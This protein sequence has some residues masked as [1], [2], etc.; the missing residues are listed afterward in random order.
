MSLITTVESLNPD[1]CIT[2]PLVVEERVKEYPAWTAEYM[3]GLR[4]VETE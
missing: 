2:T 4:R 3:S 1:K